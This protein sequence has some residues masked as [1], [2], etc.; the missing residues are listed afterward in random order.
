MIN[1]L[2][3]RLQSAR[4]MAGLSMA[5]LAEKAGSVVT[6]QAICKYEKGL[7]NPG[8]DV[9]I[10]L[11]SA[12][13]VKI[14]Y[15][16]RPATIAIDGLVFRK[17]T[18]LPKKAETQIKHQTID[19]IQKYLELEDILNIQTPFENPVRQPLVKNLKDIEAAANDIREAWKLGQGPVPH[20]TELLEDKGFKVFEVSDFEDFDGLSGFVSGVNIPV[21]AVYKGRDLT[22]KRF[23]IARELGHL[24]LDF[25]QVEEKSIEK[26]CHTFAGTLLL[27]GA[28]IQKKL[29][30]NRSKITLWELK[31]LKGVYG[32]SMQSIMARAANLSIISANAYKA[33]CINFRKKGWHREEPGQYGGKEVANRF[34]QL[35]YHGAAE[36]IISFSKAAELLNISAAQF[37][38]K[39]VFVS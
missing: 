14:D 24:L 2:G 26:L 16:F 32:I 1:E 21:V 17:K 18:G 36:Q 31:K 8:S 39:V 12:L 4:K 9:L 20:L 37:D 7:T 27:P 29:G 11:A 6:K 34:K 5:T 10:A 25:S 35:I 3:K 38:E 13:G 19:F 33:F 15:F 30:Q 23:T 28:V 22:R